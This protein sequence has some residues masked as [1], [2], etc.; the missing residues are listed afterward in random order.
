MPLPDVMMGLTNGVAITN[1]NFGWY[2]IMMFIMDIMWIL[3]SKSEYHMQF[4]LSVLKVFKRKGNVSVS[5][6]G[7]LEFLNVLLNVLICKYLS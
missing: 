1:Y 7:A 5:C 2:A 6:S 4:A 3:V